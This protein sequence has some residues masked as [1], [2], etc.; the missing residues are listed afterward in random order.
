MDRTALLSFWSK[1]WGEGLW[2]A[3]WSKSLEGLTA[4]QAAWKPAPERHSIWQIV[5]HMLFWRE[6]TLGR[7]TGKPKPTDDEIARLNYPQPREVTEAAWQALKTRFA[8]SHRRVE[9]AFG[10]PG[11]TLERISY[12]LPHD[13]Y[14]MGQICYLRAMQGLSP[15]E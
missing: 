2:A 6:D 10:D 14:H 11:T 15:I 13:C 3:P 8:D 5:S 12:L 4:E 7:L 1:A 9:A